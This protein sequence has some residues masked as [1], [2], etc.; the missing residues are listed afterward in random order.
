MKIET[1]PFNKREATLKE[2]E[3]F[4]KNAG[5]IIISAYDGESFL[6]WEKSAGYC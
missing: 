3:E 1:P 2:L 5:R 6:I 4:A